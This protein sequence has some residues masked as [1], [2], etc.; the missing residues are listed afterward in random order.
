MKPQRSTETLY[1]FRLGDADGD[2]PIWD[3]TGTTLFPGRWNSATTPVIYAAEH[4][5][6]AMLEKLVHLGG[7]APLAQHYV[8]A[9][10]PAGTLV[11]TVTPDHLPG[12]ADADLKAARAYG[13]AWAASGRGAV[14]RVPS[15]VVRL[16]WNFVFNPLHKD[17]ARIRVA[18][19]LPVWWDARL[20]SG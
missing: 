16:E 3:A 4:V 18:E 5:S 7:L 10:I 2:Y 13:D 17:F 9:T 8:R 20:F 14:L 15:Y 1:A 6:T 12:W 19:P 11:E